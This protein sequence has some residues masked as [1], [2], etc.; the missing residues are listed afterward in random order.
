VI[1]LIFL[2]R[3]R[4]FRARVVFAAGRSALELPYFS[5]ELPAQACALLEEHA[6]PMCAALACTRPQ[7]QIASI[8][9]RASLSILSFSGNR[10]SAPDLQPA[11]RNRVQL[12][13]VVAVAILCAELFFIRVFNQ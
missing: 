5:A 11:V 1:D 4:T 13:T 6:G 8:R 10:H 12:S 9:M 3:F 7:K 2:T